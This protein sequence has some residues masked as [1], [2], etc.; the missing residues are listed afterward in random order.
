MTN[1]TI[2]HVVD[3][4]DVGDNLTIYYVHEKKEKGK[5]GEENERRGR[6]LFLQ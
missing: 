6:R 3:K 4:E 1:P 5:D 2:Y